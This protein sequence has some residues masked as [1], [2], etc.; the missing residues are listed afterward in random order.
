MHISNSSPP[1]VILRHSQSGNSAL[2]K[3]FLNF[4]HQDHL[5]SLIKHRF[6]GPIPRSQDQEI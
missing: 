2:V 4:M 3:C 1:Q 6:L 5:K